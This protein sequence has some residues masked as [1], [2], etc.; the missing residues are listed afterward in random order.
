MRSQSIYPSF[1]FVIVI[2][3]WILFPAEVLASTTNAE[4]GALAE[5]FYEGFDSVEFPPPT[6]SLTDFGSSDYGW[7]H[8]TWTYY[9]GGGAAYSNWDLDDI[10][11]WLISPAIV[12]EDG[13][14]YN[15]EFFQR[16]YNYGVGGTSAIMVSTKSNQAGSSDFV[17]LYQI[18]QAYPVFTETNISMNEFAGNIIYLAFVHQ[19]T[20]AHEW[21][22][23]E[24]K[25]HEIENVDAGITGLIS[26]TALIEPGSY[27]VIVEMK[28]YGSTTITSLDITYEIGDYTETV[29]W[30][31][32]LEP[33]TTTPVSIISSF[34]F[35][36]AG[37]Y[38]ITATTMLENDGNPSN[39]SFTADILSSESCNYTVYMTSLTGNG[40]HG[41]LIGFQQAGITIAAFGS[42]FTEGSSL[43]PLDISIADAY[44][45]DL[46]A[47][48]AG[49]FSSS[50]GFTLIGPQGDTIHHHNF[51]APFFPGDVFNS[52]LSDCSLFD[53]D[54]GI[55][56]FSIEE[57]FVGDEVTAVAQ[58]QNYGSNE[59]SF[60]VNLEIR[61]ADNVVTETQHVFLANI[62]TAM[63]ETIDF[64]P[65]D[66]VPG[67]YS[68]IVSIVWDED[69]NPGND[70]MTRYFDAFDGILV[71]YDD[72]INNDLIGWSVPVWDA[73]IMFEPEDWVAYG[74]GEI[75]H[76]RLYVG[77]A[78]NNMELKIW[79]GPGAEAEIFSQAFEPAAFSWNIVALDL[80]QTIDPNSDLYVGVR[81]YGAP[82]VM[83]MGVDAQLNYPG[84][85]DLFRWEGEHTWYPTGDEWNLQFI[86]MPKESTFTVTFVVNDI[87]NFPVDGAIVSLEGYGSQTT[88]NGQTIFS[89]IPAT[90]DPGIPYLINA[91]GCIDISGSV[92]VEDHTTVEVTCLIVGL[93]SKSNGIIMVFPNPAH[94]GLQIN[95]EN[96]RLLGVQMINQNGVVVLTSTEGFLNV[97]DLPQGIYILRV[98]T[99]K[100]VYQ[101]RV[102]VQ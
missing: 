27:E 28:N 99:D 55:V 83:A 79:Q 57:L 61:N 60:F 10:D 48:N 52:F 97:A 89:E 4:K 88:V 6:W 46:I 100:G 93:V 38:T 94:M 77:Q 82:F 11:T 18:D 68:A 101:E 78:P 1:L 81:I 37:P 40:F 35:S 13:V 15:L 30:S 50:L 67:N 63:M 69:Q 45:T 2:T 86:F 95:V 87:D 59:A 96:E 85:S 54:A 39:D 47:L 9:E 20:N 34:D 65:M 62:E 51:G 7:E 12:L 74:E 32:L 64:D 8:A 16:N 25:V 22:I 41:A 72:G 33:N 66:L 92:V 76:L 26:P 17:M 102:V 21:V 36:G 90:P 70:S 91:E 80:P 49:D 24:V 75:T 42:E 53:Y 56:A 29:F 58:V 23:D 19:G 14:Q 31:G 43:G 73:A 98:A 71:H 84:K 5:V 3:L 44:Q